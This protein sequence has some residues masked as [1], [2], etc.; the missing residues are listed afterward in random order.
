[1]AR[2]PGGW[3]IDTVASTVVVLAL[4]VAINVVLWLV[5]HRRRAWIK[6]PAYVVGGL[7]VV[8]PVGAG[9]NAYYAYFPTVGTLL[10]RRAALQMS[11]ADILRL[12]ARSRTERFAMGPVH[13]D[14]WTLF[15]TSSAPSE[16][17]RADPANDV[18]AAVTTTAP[19]RAP[20]HG[21]VDE[22]A[23]PGT[24]S[25][26]HARSAQVYLPPIWFAPHRPSLPVIM[27]LH[28]S[29][30]EPAD[31]TR[32]GM[33]DLA[34]EAWAESHGG[35]APIIVMPDP[36]GDRFADSECMDGNV[37]KADTYLTTDVRNFVVESYGASLDRASWAVGGL[38][39]GGTCSIH[40]AL[41][42][43]EAFSAFLAYGADA[44]VTTATVERVLGTRGIFSRA[45]ADAFSPLTL[46][47]KAHDEGVSGAICSGTGEAG[48]ELAARQLMARAADTD[49]DL[50]LVLLPGGHHTFRVWRDCFARTLPW[51]APRLRVGPELIAGANRGVT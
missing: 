37:G 9:A 5:V 24:V 8:A 39:E 25:G 20:G 47:A 7:L 41:R 6:V 43:P 40:L 17:S 49:A 21:A 46:I 33:A 27:L 19:S 22:V 3:P 10:G 44:R 15:P 35:L 28:G 18:R 16:A 48:D 23:I 2:S 32:G 34:T 1:M 26:F 4:F 30:G 14:L 51:V 36:N 12:A 50:Q 11:H 29:P 42:H 13:R 45:A 31:W 38:S